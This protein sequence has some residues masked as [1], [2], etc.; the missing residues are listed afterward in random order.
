MFFDTRPKKKSKRKKSKKSKRSK[1][2]KE[3]SEKKYDTKIDT[4][5][6]PKLIIHQI[7]GVFRDGKPLSD[8]P[9]FVDSKKAWT[10]LAKKAG[11]RYK[12]W[13]DAMCT[14]LINK[15]PEFKKMYN[16]VKEPVMRADIMRFLILY[17][18]G[19]MYV[20]MDVFPLKKKYEYDRLAF[21]EYYYTP[22]KPHTN[23]DMEVIYAPKGSKVMYDFLKF[24][25]T[26]IKEKSKTLPKSWKVRYI[27]YTT[28]PRS[29]MKFLKKHDIDYD[30]IKSNL[31]K[32]DSLRKFKGVDY[33]VVSYFSMSY[34]PHAKNVGYTKKKG[35]NK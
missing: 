19:G 27:F 12:L 33:D 26:Q 13:N 21:C 14:K 17:D 15:Y 32:E 20:D 22:N 16:S 29:L 3:E 2:V 6:R 28:G 9:L 34:N 7:Y 5:N 30:E 18:E 24:V 11:Y 10:A 31:G 1:K 4:K 8:F 35:K 25:E 23:T